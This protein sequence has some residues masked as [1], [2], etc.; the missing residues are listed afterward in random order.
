MELDKLHVHMFSLLW[1]L[2]LRE[3]GGKKM[4]FK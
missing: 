4:D 3:C 1:H 2:K